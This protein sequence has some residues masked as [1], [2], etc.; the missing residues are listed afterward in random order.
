MGRG[1]GGGE[2]ESIF[3][4]ELA[5]EGSQGKSSELLI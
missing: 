3:F 4:F 2:G 5:A 1:K